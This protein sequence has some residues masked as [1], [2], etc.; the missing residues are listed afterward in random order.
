MNFNI[1]GTDVSMN[2]KL[3]GIILCTLLIATVVLPVTAMQK[4]QD[5]ANNVGIIPI[6]YDLPPPLPVDML[7]EKSICRRMSVRDFTGVAV[8]D[9]ELSTILWAAY[10][11]RDNGGR[12]IFSPNGAYSTVIYV[13]RSDATYKYVPEDHSLSLFKN[14][15]YLSIGQYDTAPIKFGL[16]WDTSITPAEK[17]GMAEIGKIGQN[18]YFDANALNLGTVTTGMGVDELHQLGIPANEVPEII[19]PLGHPSSPYNFAYNPLPVSNLPK[20]IN[21]TLSL[22]DAINNRYIVNIWDNV[23]LSLLEQS[24]LIWSSYGYSYYF[25][26]VN[27]KRHRTLP[28]A[29][30]IYPF[31]IFAANQSGVYQYSPST[32]S[33]TTIVQGDRR[34][35]IN[36]SIESN[37]ITTTSS[38]WIIIAF[39][40]TNIGQSQYQRFWYYE[41]GAITHNVLL[42][43]S[44]LN[45]SSN[46]ITGISNEAGLR[47]A[48]GISSQTNLLPLSVILVGG[49]YAPSNH[50]PEIPDI[51]GPD[52]GK[53]GT[54]YIYTFNTTDPDSDDIYYY[55]YWGDNTNSGWIGP[56]SSGETIQTNHTWSKKGTYVIRCKAKDIYGAESD[57]GTLSVSMP[58]TISFNSLFMRFL[59]QFPHSFPI[60]RHLMES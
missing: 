45:L 10:G 33:I 47:S 31:K 14:G 13:I 57:W 30:D 49:P 27:N 42:E 59:E 21:N 37:N 38:P 28:S 43:A 54:E 9:E 32:H 6:K 17:D 34:E 44:A 36:N 41:A 50:Q 56:Y 12:T 2:K 51:S 26:N 46:V 53:A 23:P 29:I 48:L 18:I 52:S 58:R 4:T 39:L 7:L 16:V 35:E 40:D 3:L 20:V 55:I 15:N 1:W 25:D 22:A 19:M 24:Q 5:S 8:T 11:Y 60:L